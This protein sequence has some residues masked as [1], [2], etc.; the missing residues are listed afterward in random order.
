MK[1]QTRL[2]LATSSLALALSFPGVLNASEDLISEDNQAPLSKVVAPDSALGDETKKDETVS[3][4]S[5]WS[6]GKILTL[7]LW[8]STTAPDEAPVT[9][10]S[11]EDEDKGDEAATE[12]PQIQESAETTELTEVEK[13]KAQ[14]ALQE[15]ELRRREEE[16]EF[17]KKRQEEA[18]QGYKSDLS[19]KNEELLRKEREVEEAQKTLEAVQN[20]LS[21][22]KFYIAEKE[23]SLLEIENE[24]KKAE[25]ELQLMEN[26]IETLKEFIE[27][28]EAEKKLNAEQVESEKAELQSLI[29]STEI[30]ESEKEKYEKKLKDLK[31]KQN[32]LNKSHQEKN[33]L[34]AEKNK[35]LSDRNT[36]V[37]K[38]RIAR[39]Q[40]QKKVRTLQADYKKVKAKNDELS[41]QKE[42]LEGDLLV[43][44][45]RIED[46]F[47]ARIEDLS[48][49]TLFFLK[50]KRGTRIKFDHP[51]S[52]TCLQHVD[53]GEKDQTA[54]RKSL[55]IYREGIYVF[56]KGNA[57]TACSSDTINNNTSLDQVKG[58]TVYNKGDILFTNM[59]P[60][61]D[62]SIYLVTS[63]GGKKSQVKGANLP[64]FLAKQ[65][66]KNKQIV[67]KKK[68]VAK[69]S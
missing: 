17:L 36:E 9:T 11:P 37:K 54:G 33:K 48:E 59:D 64:N 60:F 20:E 51:D 53:F 3:E 38:L 22:Q 58:V 42:R 55:P 25:A 4:G 44:K 14:L 19:Q 46:T 41:E 31:A 56:Q 66:M 5:S 6:W 61:E 50:E 32:K 69:T 13:L 24:A 67:I 26:E 68:K 15:A 52:W 2:L 28:E 23:K 27:K 45:K 62:N 65:N 12:T 63:K 29:G 16:N 43:M 35:L 49:S 7:G 40:Q 1:T 30:S 57:Y 47:G 39:D 21:L 8:S 18:H 34:L 10:A